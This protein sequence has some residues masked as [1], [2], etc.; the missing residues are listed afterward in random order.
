MPPHDE[1]KKP[2]GSAAQKNQIEFMPPS[3]GGDRNSAHWI[4]DDDDYLDGFY[5][6]D[7]ASDGDQKQRVRDEKP[8]QQQKKKGAEDE[9]REAGK[10]T[11]KTKTKTKEKK[12]RQTPPTPRSAER[13]KTIMVGGGGKF[14]IAWVRAL[15]WAQSNQRLACMDL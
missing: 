7:R 12:R 14:A 3:Q 1:Q 4:T 5:V 13:R 6:F 11:E 2:R 9:D 15:T 10:R 8:K